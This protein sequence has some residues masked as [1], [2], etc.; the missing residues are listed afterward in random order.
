MTGTDIK[1]LSTVR[2]EHTGWYGAIVR[3]ALYPE[4]VINIKPPQSF[5]E[6]I[7][8]GQ[9]DA[10][11]PATSVERLRK[12]HDDLHE[13]G[14]QFKAAPREMSL[15]PFDRFTLLFEEFLNHLT[16]VE[17]DLA[18]ENSGMDPTTGLRSR[19]VMMADIAREVDRM[20]RQGKAFSLAVTKIDDYETYA[21][22]LRPEQLQGYVRQL[23]GMVQKSIRTFDD[24]YASAPGEFVLS[25]K[26]SNIGGGFRALERLRKALIEG[27]LE[28][29]L[30]D[31]AV[32]LS[33]SC[34]VGE[35]H[36]G[37]NLELFINELRR[38]MRDSVREPGTVLKYHE[39]APLKRFVNTGAE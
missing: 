9:G 38:D 39:L 26:Q 10:V 30:K 18:V 31:G 17:Q 14:K 27:H 37:D 4:G 22:Q 7:K 25:F 35:P 5:N 32:P 21:A 6:W 33:L 23:A 24:A 8:S 13:A 36:P 20:N 16:R 2:E 3:H 12:I 19:S 34:C 11:M 1:P 29:P 15:E 28:I